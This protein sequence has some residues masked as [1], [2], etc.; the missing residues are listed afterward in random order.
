MTKI[1]YETNITS[2][3]PVQIMNVSLIVVAETGDGKIVTNNRVFHVIESGKSFDIM[4]TEHPSA[5]DFESQIKKVLDEMINEI[6][7]KRMTF[8]SVSQFI[9]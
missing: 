4:V 2:E 7:V 3:Q 6:N 9:F 1:I 8:V 5:K